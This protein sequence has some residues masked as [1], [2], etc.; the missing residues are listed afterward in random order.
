M[1]VHAEQLGLARRHGDRLE[2]LARPDHPGVVPLAEQLVQRATL[3]VAGEQARKAR[4]GQ[5]DLL[6]EERL[7]VGH[8]QALEVDDG[9]ADRDVQGLRD[10]RVSGH[11]AGRDDARRRV[12]AE[13]LHLFG[14]R[15][16]AVE[17][18][19]DRGAGHERAAAAG[20]LQAVLA[21][22]VAERAPD[23][24]QAA[25]VPLGQLAL[26][27]QPVAGAPFARLER[28]A[29]V[30]IDLVVE[31]DRARQEP[32]A[33]HARREEPRAVGRGGGLRLAMLLLTL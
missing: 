8:A 9:R 26:G 14:E 30:K 23:G 16:R 11:R 10:A 13:A 24:D 5:E 1:R 29:Q 3:E 2:R 31:R 32:E 21:R 33:C 20:P 4:L 15:H 25:A 28:G 7:A 12:V 27:R 18:E 6:E 17:V 19:V 22:Q